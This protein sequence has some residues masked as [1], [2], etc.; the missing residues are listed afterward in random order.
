MK[1][2]TRASMSTRAI[3]KLNQNDVEGA[4]IALVALRITQP[5]IEGKERDDMRHYDMGSAIMEDCCP[6]LR[7]P[8]DVL[9]PEEGKAADVMLDAIL[10]KAHRMEKELLSSGDPLIRALLAA[11]PTAAE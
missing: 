1:M 11:L 10:D 6:L 7:V 2:S 5:E 4:A 8:E 9:T 3:S